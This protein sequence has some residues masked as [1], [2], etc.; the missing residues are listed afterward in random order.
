MGSSNITGGLENPQFHSDAPVKRSGGA[1]RSVGGGFSSSLFDDDFFKSIKEQTTSGDKGARGGH[2]QSY[3]YSYSNVNGDEK[4]VKA[5]NVNG[6][7][8]YQAKHNGKV[9]DERLDDLD[10]AGT[11]SIDGRSRS[12][13]C[14][15]HLSQTCHAAPRRAEASTRRPARSTRGS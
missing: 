8:S 2:F 13:R 15:T 6:K 7:K 11:S 10:R 3:S 14:S 12:R 5:K 1:L 4:E 9:I